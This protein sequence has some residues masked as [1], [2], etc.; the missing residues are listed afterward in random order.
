[1]LLGGLFVTGLGYFFHASLLARHPTAASIIGF[2]LVIL[3]LMGSALAIY[4]LLKRPPVLVIDHEGILAAQRSSDRVLWSDLKG[5]H[6]AE[7]DRA[8]PST[9]S[10]CSASRTTSLLWSLLILRRSPISYEH[11][12]TDASRLLYLVTEGIAR[13]G[14]LAHPMPIRRRSIRS[15]EC[16]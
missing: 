13:Q 6:L 9:P 3:G 5:A 10:A 12:D 1:M 11:L 2:L 4:W 15:P 14:K 8:S 16:S 7:C